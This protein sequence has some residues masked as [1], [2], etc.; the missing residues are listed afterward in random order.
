MQAIKATSTLILALGLATALIAG[1]QESDELQARIKSDRV[2]LRAKPDGASEV[3][4]Q[5]T[6]D[7]RL[8]VRAVEPDWV[9][10]SPPERV[11]LWVHKDFVKDGLSVGEKVNVRA[12]AGINFSVVGNYTRGERVEVRGQFGEWLKVAPSN[13][14]LWVSR[15]LVD[16]LYPARLVEPAPAPL[17]DAPM[18]AHPLPAGPMQ[19][20]GGEPDLGPVSPAPAIGQSILAPSAD[21]ASPDKRMAE[22]P[23]DLNLVPLEGQGRLVQYEGELKLAPFMFGRPSKFRITRRT[24]NQIHTV[25]FVRGNSQQ[26]ES[27]L[28]QRLLVRGREYWVQGVR[29]P[30]LVLER[31]ERP[32]R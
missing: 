4:A 23:R 30:V 11:D 15:A 8:R 28:N 9:Q 3:V 6:L 22:A 21:P 16:L 31:I 32:A 1:A 17:V 2:N 5:A 13:A 12:G 18:P 24:A 27:L 19:E 7:E 29:Q 26:L 14:A 25:C 10:V 20:A